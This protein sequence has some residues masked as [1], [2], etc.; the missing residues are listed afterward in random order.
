MRIAITK[1][2]F[3]PANRHYLG[4]NLQFASP[5]LAT[6]PLMLGNRLS[7]DQKRYRLWR[8]CRTKKGERSNSQSSL[9]GTGGDKLHR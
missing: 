9:L 3:I 1:L 4:W 7:I 6:L 8:F 5:F 2:Q